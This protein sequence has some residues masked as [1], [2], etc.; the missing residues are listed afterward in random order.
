MY[1][2]EQKV[3]HALYGLGTVEKI[4]E[5]NILGKLNRYAVISFQ[6]E[7]MQIMVNLEQKSE[8]I[9][10]PVTKDDVPRIM[11]FLKECQSPLPVKSPDRFNINMGKIKSADIYKLVE[12]IKDL[13]CLSKEK[14]LTPKELTMLK[15]SQKM[16]CTEMC[17]VTEIASQEMEEMVERYSKS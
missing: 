1:Q 4:E 2:I 14:K 9:R 7:R 16:L 8:L 15:Q 6:N 13:S 12:V 10:E 3:I 11:E 5:K 17:L